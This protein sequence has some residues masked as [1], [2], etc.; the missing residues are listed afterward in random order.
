MSEEN[1]EIKS[2]EIKSE[3]TKH[4]ADVVAIPSKT[5]KEKANKFTNR[6]KR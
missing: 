1:K 3:D 5:L 2:E 4:Y 6:F